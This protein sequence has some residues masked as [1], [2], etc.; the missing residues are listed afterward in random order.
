MMSC[1]LCLT[2]QKYFMNS[3]NRGPHLPSSE[4]APGSAVTSG[5]NLAARW[6][7]AFFPPHISASCISGHTV[8]DDDEVIQRNQHKNSFT[9]NVRFQTLT[10]AIRDGT[11]PLGTFVRRRLCQKGRWVPAETLLDKGTELWWKLGQ[12]A[13]LPGER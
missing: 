6:L 8:S 13:G 1:C 11:S 12:G 3:H 7:S 2:F 5:D 10:L 4:L 9:K